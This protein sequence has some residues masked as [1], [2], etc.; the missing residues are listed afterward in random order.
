MHEDKFENWLSFL[1]AIFR[2]VDVIYS[3]LCLECAAT[4]DQSYKNIVKNLKK[5]L[6]PNGYIYLF[7]VL[8]ESFYDVLDQKLFCHPQSE[9]LLR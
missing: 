3:S 9:R 1:M 5:F 4:S 2:K 8:E 6:K 7:G